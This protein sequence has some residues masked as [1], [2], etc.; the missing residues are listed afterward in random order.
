MRSVRL[1]LRAEWRRRWA[2]WAALA[3]LVA[4]TGGTVLAGVSAAN[5]T[6]SAFPH[7]AALYGYDADVFGEK[8]FPK[9]F[10]H[11]AHVTAV[12]QSEYYFNG[13]VI[14]NGHFVPAEAVNVIGLP[15]SHLTSTIK[16]LSGHLPTA[17]GDAVVGYDMQ[18]QFNLKIGSI[19]TVPFFAPSQRHA[20]LNSNTAVAAHGPRV[21]LRVVGFEASLL[22]FPTISPSYS[23][24]VSGAF[25]KSVG[26][27]VVTGNYAQVRLSGGQ[28][29]MPHYQYLVNNDLGKHGEFFVQDEDTSTVAIESS[30]HPQAIGWW[31]FSLFAALAGLV[32]IGQA[33]SRQNRLESESYP[34][35]AALGIRPN[36]F[37]GLGMLRAG[38]IGAMG[39]LGALI[40]ATALSPLT[41]VGE[42]R[43]AELSHGFV[44]LGPL[45]VLG[46]VSIIA[47]VL[48]LSVVPAWRAAQVQRESS[49]R[50]EISAKGKTT[51][52]TLI[53]RTGSP[54]SVLIGVR[55]ALE[56]GR[57]RSSVPA[58]TA[59]V[60][61][62]LAVG[63]LVISTIFG[64]S[65]SNLLRTPRLFGANW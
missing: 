45:L 48:A 20:V 65:L 6:A 51:L 56:R 23:I 40:F 32:L 13:N 9:D 27:L 18:Q 38:V 4:L 54:P 8:A 41:P 49:R 11:I 39:A 30:I 3:V 21:H 33:L 61:T 25:A 7:F 58:T 2:S 1:L 64:A 34:T 53:A 57:G 46:F 43:A 37:F 60:G 50:V 24:Y 22:D 55:N 26:P 63:A 10:D 19:V 16:L 5:R 47:V 31:L 36:Q 29:D 12:A 35:L 62:V 17:S 14:A 28:A 44:F 42:A 52:A 15:T 59:L